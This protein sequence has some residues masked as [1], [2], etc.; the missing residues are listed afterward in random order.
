[1]ALTKVVNNSIDG[2]A[3]S[4]LTG[5]V[6]DARFPATLPAVDGSNLTGISAVT[7]SASEPTAT[8]NGT[9]GDLYLNTTSGEMYS[10]TDATTNANVWTNV[11]DGTGNQPFNYTVATGGTI[12]TDGDYKVHSFTS[13][14]TFSFNVTTAG[15]LPEVEYLVIAGGGGGGTFGG[16][17]AGGY[18]TATGFDVTAT[19]YTVTVGAGGSES[20]SEDGSRGG[21]GSNSVFSSITS[22]G[23]GGGGAF[24][25][26]NRNGRPGGS[27]GGAGCGHTSPYA[28][29]VIG[30][31]N[32]GGFSPVEGYNGGLAVAGA[33]AG[34]SGG[35]ASA[36]GGNASSGVGGN[37]G[38]GRASSITGSSIT[39]A[40]GGGGPG[41]STRGAA[42][43]GGGGQGDL[44][45]NSMTAGG[46][47]LGGG[48]GGSYTYAG[49]AG[50]SGIVIIRYKFQ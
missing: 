1:M 28:S 2:M 41:A 29:G 19:G 15:T 9:L 36:V 14:G 6:A 24:N 12:T 31:G 13:S 10:L 25:N 23:G 17:G 16:G 27:G 21:I 39:R 48:G 7:K 11:G 42:G 4:K 8:I 50:G 33:T 30:A 32:E 47:N 5:T 18:R 3:T 20:G 40:G 43:S 38:A 34:G 35:G 44:T 46:T 45:D 26:T 49:A 37:G 22:N